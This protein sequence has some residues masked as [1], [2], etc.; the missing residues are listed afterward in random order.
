[1]ATYQE[2]L[3]AAER[4]AH[5]KRVE[6]SAVKLLLLHFA[7]L[8]ST[9]LY[10][11]L[12]H[13]MPEANRAAFETA[14]KRHIE[15]HVPV[16]YLVGHVWFYGYRFLVDDRVL[17]P[18]FET[19]EL[20]ANILVQYDETFAKQPVDV[21]DVGTGS[22]CL[23]ITLAM[24]EP[25]FTVTA[26]DISEAALAVAREN[27]TAI[28]ANVSFLAGDMLAPLQGRKFDILVSNPPY[29]PV[30]EALAPVIAGHEPDVALFG[31]DDGLKFYRI[32]LSGAAAILKP[33]SFLAFEHGF[34]KAAELRK[35][36][37][38]HFPSARIYTLADLQG[39]D[40]M[41]FIING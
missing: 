32:I 31:G 17:I 21:V 2:I 11:S 27:A 6:A 24:E 9:E 30:G 36:A 28:G 19:E 23:A 8:S 20:V 22:G 12:D 15:E 3:R 26:T 1:M 29:I 5:Q 14:V 40:R 25:H 37:S 13:E 33:K 4:Q 10:T 16:Q 39:R 41:T 35:I 18:R 38:I 7:G 34:D